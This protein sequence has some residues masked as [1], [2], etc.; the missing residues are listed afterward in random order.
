MPSNRLLF[1]DK[2]FSIDKVKGVAGREQRGNQDSTPRTSTAPELEELI[3]VEISLRSA[4]SP[5]AAAAEAVQ[6]EMP[7]EGVP[8]API[9]HTGW[10]LRGVRL[11]LDAV[12]RVAVPRDELIPEAVHDHKLPDSSV[13]QH[14]QLNGKML[15]SITR[16]AVNSCAHSHVHSINLHLVS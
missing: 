9:N 13:Q 10:V 6:P 8:R 2:G 12:I 16:I 11:G 5:E 15:V 4:L 3:G 7:S 1:A 14:V